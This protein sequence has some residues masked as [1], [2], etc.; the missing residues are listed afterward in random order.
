MVSS[1]QRKAGRWTGPFL[2]PA[3]AALSLAVAGGA[4][5]SSPA[6]AQAVI[7]GN[8][9]TT[10]TVETVDAQTRMVLLRD[11]KGGLI[12]L[13]IP[14]DARDLPRLEPGDRISLRFFQTMAADIATPG[15]P[16]PES[17]VSS[18]RG[19][20][21]RHPHGTMVSFQ[22]ERVR[23]LAVDPA[24]HKV[25]FIDPSDITRTVTIRKKAMQALLPSLKVGDQVDVT[26]M[27]AVSFSVLNRTIN[28]DVSVT[29]KAGTQETPKAAAK[30]APGP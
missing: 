12:T 16:Q 17:T 5:P 23:I 18:A 30:P 25:T 11:R 2:H 6:F 29:E 7:T 15:S 3:L 1:T 24:A 20:A 10:A 14:R 26:T 28:G 9:T 27:D 21:R 22:R 19:Y 8:Q 4:I 13:T